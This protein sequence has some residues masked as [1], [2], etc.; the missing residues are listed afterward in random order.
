MHIFWLGG[1]V[2]GVGGRRVCQCDPQLRMNIE[3]VL[4]YSVWLCID[5]PTQQKHVSI[6]SVLH[7]STSSERCH[8]IEY[9]NLLFINSSRTN[10]DA[11]FSLLFWMISGGRSGLTEQQGVF[12]NKKTVAAIIARIIIPLCFYLPLQ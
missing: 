1:H 7:T 10:C 3:N 11:S 2:V 4:K 6:S 5:I 8:V 12:M 9:C